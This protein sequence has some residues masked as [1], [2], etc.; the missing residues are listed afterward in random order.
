MARAITQVC[1][2]TLSCTQPAANPRT[3]RC[4]QHED[5]WRAAANH[6][7]ALVYR[8]VHE[9]GKHPGDRAAFIANELTEPDDVC[10]WIT[11]AE[12]AALR[13]VLHTASEDRRQMVA[14]L[15]RL[16]AV[17]VRLDQIAKTLPMT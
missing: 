13:N 17:R 12:R 6:Y 7:R 2:A 4:A 1:E 8:S 11:G 9:G 16:T 15:D 3:K 5:E 14:T 10:V